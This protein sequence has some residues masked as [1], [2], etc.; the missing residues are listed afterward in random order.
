[1]CGSQMDLLA[2]EG[3]RWTLLVLDFDFMAL[4]SKGKGIAYFKCYLM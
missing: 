1:M 4:A 2:L 3:A